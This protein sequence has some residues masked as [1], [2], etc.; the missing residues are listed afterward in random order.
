MTLY[1]I[2]DVLNGNLAELIDALQFAENASKL[3]Q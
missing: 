2:Q 1:N 3:T